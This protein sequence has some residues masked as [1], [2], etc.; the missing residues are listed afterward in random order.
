M[1]IGQFTVYSLQ[2]TAHN[3]VAVPIQLSNISYQIL[4]SQCEV[5]P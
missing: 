1:T 2:F 4:D 5:T 3:R